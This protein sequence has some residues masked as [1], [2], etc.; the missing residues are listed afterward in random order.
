MKKIQMR[1]ATM[2]ARLCGIGLS[3]L[4]LSTCD[5]DNDN[6]VYPMYGT[7]TGTFEVKGDVTSEEGKPV[8][9][10]KIT[11]KTVYEQEKYNESI[12]ETTT[13][14]FGEYIVKKQRY[15]STPAIRVVCTPPEDSDLKADSTDVHLDFKGGDGNW[16]IGTATATADFR[17]RK[18]K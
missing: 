1:A 11:V 8:E 6:R 5:K 4:G 9:A 2:A 7:P 18:K 13:S 15:D 14:E 16:N 12:A 17:L 10:A 3:L